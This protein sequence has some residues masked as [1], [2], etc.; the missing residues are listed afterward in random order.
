MAISK[1]LKYTVAGLFA[2][3]LFL[4]AVVAVFA[5]PQTASTSA[6][7]PAVAVD[8]V[9][10]P[11]QEQAAADYEARIRRVANMSDFVVDIRL[12]LIDGLVEIEVTPF[13]ASQHKA[14]RQDFAVALW[15]T[16][17]SASG[18]ED[19][20]KARIRLVNRQGQQVGGSRAI[21]GSVIYV[22]D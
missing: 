9:E 20:D 22:D 6:A 2:A 11:T 15:E 16:W 7:A 1:P 14:A 5:P 13:Y 18:V 10:K 21:A 4:P 12:G 19:V 8:L 3:V 17:A